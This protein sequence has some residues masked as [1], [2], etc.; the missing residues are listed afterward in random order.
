MVVVVVQCSVLPPTWVTPQSTSVF[1]LVKTGVI[2]TSQ[3]V[4]SFS[5][6][7]SSQGRRKVLLTPPSDE[8]S[9]LISFVF[10]AKTVILFLI[11]A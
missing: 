2:L 10:S 8:K 11:K 1:P 3:S 5:S 4:I 9:V 6:F 7:P